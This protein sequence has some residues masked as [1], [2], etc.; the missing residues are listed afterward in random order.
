M[1]FGMLLA[2]GYI[3]STQSSYVKKLNNNDGLPIPEWRLPPVIVGGVS[4]TIGLFFFAWTGCKSQT[5]SSLVFQ[6]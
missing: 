1:V 3:I 6:W 2:G 5:A 4:F